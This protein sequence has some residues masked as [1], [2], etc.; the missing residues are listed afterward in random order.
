MNR[1][2][3]TISGSAGGAGCGDGDDD[4]QIPYHHERCACFHKETLYNV[5]AAAQKVG[6]GLKSVGADCMGST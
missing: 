2:I 3:W 4:D 1:N 5:P 6:P